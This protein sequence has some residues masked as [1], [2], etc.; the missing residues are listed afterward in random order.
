MK[1]TK[2]QLAQSLQGMQYKD[3]SEEVL[4]TAKDN[5]LVIVSG[6]S[7]DGIQ[8]DGAIDDLT[9]IYKAQTIR[10]DRNGVIPEWEEFDKEDMDEVRAYIKAIDNKEYGE[11]TGIWGEGDYGWHYET[12]IPHVTFEVLDDDQKYCLG[13]VFAIEDIAGNG[14]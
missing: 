7:D 3:F 5:D 11:I 10:F 8:F 4:K 14:F 9:Y 2:E 1:V 6:F 12:E 13:I